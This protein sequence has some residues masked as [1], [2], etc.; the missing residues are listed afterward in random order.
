[1]GTGEG[2]NAG[3]GAAGSSGGGSRKGR[4]SG[5]VASAVDQCAEALLRVWLESESDSSATSSRVKSES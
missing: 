5:G 4:D 2:V 3:A 1:V